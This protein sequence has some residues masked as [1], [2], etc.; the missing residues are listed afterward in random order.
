MPDR[1]FTE[2]DADA[3]IASALRRET[4][5]WP[6]GGGERLARLVLVRSHHHGVQPLLHDR[7][8]ETSSWP[9]AMRAEMRAQSLARAM[10]ELR[11]QETLGQV[12]AALGKGGIHP[13]LIKGSALAYSLYRDPA[14]RVRGD[15]DLIIEADRMEDADR[16]LTA[17]GLARDIGAEGEVV[18]YHSSYTRAAPDRTSHTIEVHSRL[19]ISRLLSSL[20][21]HGEL[22]ANAV[23]LPRLAPGAVGH[24]LEDA[25]FVTA[26]HRASHRHKA[27][28]SDGKAYYSSDRMIWL[29]DIDLIARH[30]DAS[31]WDRLVARAWNKNLVR[32]VREALEAA[33]EVFATPVPAPV[34]AALGIADRDETIARCVGATHLG[35]QLIDLRHLPGLA[36]KLR[37]ARELFFPPGAFMHG[38]YPDARVRWLPW[39]YA[40]RIFDV[41]MKT[42]DRNRQAT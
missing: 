36:N 12:L 10:W 18:S 32:V 14:L 23:S 15:T 20:L 27:F 9:A 38:K 35:Q 25:L 21:P 5:P 30:L 40:R 29:Y 11:H 8:D 31:G 4:A 42:L 13:V 2:S 37:F 24:G 6:N 19:G 41:G 26:L 1:V 7:E 3:L 39:L 17:L 28:Y 22:L 34:S 16:I 33:R